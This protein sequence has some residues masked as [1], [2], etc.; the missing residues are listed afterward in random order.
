MRRELKGRKGKKKQESE[1]RL[2]VWEQLFFLNFIMILVGKLILKSVD[3]YGKKGEFLR[4][5]YYDAYF[6]KKAER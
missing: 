6:E 4:E 2:K 5:L 3:K 1:V